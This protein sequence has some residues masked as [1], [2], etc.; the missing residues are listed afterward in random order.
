MLLYQM[1][2]KHFY[3]SVRAAANSGYTK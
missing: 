1:F 2:L 3:S